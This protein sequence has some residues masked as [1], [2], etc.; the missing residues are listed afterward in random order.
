MSQHFNLN[1]QNN[2]IAPLFT[3]HL[4]P[5]V[6]EEDDQAQ[7]RV[8]FEA[9]P[10]P[11][12][13]W[14]RY[15]FE[16]KS[17]NDIKIMEQNNSS[18]LYI[19]KACLDDTGIFTCLL[20]NPAGSTKSSTNLTV[21]EKNPQTE[22]QEENQETSMMESMTT[23][24]SS[25]FIEQQQQ[26]ESSS[27]MTQQNQSSST[28]SQSTQQVQ[29]KQSSSTMIQSK[30][31]NNMIESQQKS[32]KNITNTNTKKSMNKS[33]NNKNKIENQ[34][35]MHVKKKDKIRID[36]QFK[37]GSKSDLT[38]T[39]DG[40]T[41]TESNQEGIEITFS[42]DIATLTI[43]NAEEKHSGLYQCIMKTEGGEARCSVNCQVE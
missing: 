26:Q 11:V 29:Q 8:E 13:K 1:F 24:T 3:T 17:G 23:Y 33:E 16:L 38:F 7:F 22:E 43:D 18:T 27:A 2:F 30:S 9:H 42:N 19:K 4:E 28:M 21:L 34:K 39:H 37:D 31:S 32:N 6:V 5:V 20:E 10:R 36:I 15:T 35:I 12:I 25:S 41:L 40:I 14:L